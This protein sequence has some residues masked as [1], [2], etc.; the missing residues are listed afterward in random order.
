MALVG[1]FLSFFARRLVYPFE[2]EWME[3]GAVTHIQVVLAGKPLYR[4]PSLEFT[5]YLY[6]PV[7]TYVSAAF[8]RVVGV[9]LFAPRLVSVLA[10]VGSGVLIARFVRGEGGRR[11]ATLA[12]LSFFAV[13]FSR[14]GFFM[15]L[16]R[17]DSLFLFL[18]LFATHTLRFGTATWSAVASGL[19]FT[20]AFYTKQTGLLAS[21]A[22][23][24]GALLGFRKRALIAG[25]TFAVAAGVVFLLANRATDGWFRFYLF[26]LPRS[27]KMMWESAWH[28][29]LASVWWPLPIAFL[30]ALA[31]FASDLV[32]DRRRFLYLGLSAGT[33]AGGYTSL[34][35]QDG[36]ING[37][38]PWLGVLSI[39]AGIGV[40]TILRFAED[41]RRWRNFTLGLVALQW[42]VTYYPFRD[43]LP[44]R[45]DRAAGDALIERLRK[46][47]KP[48]LSLTS[49]YYVTMAGQTET[50]AQTMALIDVL[51]QKDPERTKKLVGELCDAIAN[52]HY[53]TVITDDPTT[54]FPP[55]VMSSIKAHYSETYSPPF[56][57][58][59]VAYPRTGVHTRPKAIWTRR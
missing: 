46:E 22:V 20:A 45:R 12:A 37:I 56:A 19:L 4:E 40:E 35:K 50:N 51:N 26:T 30:F 36:F 5:P 11:V 21:A 8:A 55:E 13:S 14:S 10:T 18:V 53:A 7:F 38:L 9:S 44:T 43:Q 29:V 54:W 15:D 32:R 59:G 24:V 58:D 57:E 48:I 17:V 31:G 2:L 16:A 41:H 6:P 28:N 25:A 49:N 33:L 23:L 1:V 42:A 3:G 39:V 52:G 34:M 47:K 27:H